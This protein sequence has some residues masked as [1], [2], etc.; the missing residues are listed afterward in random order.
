MN[1]II[2]FADMMLDGDLPNEQREH[3]EIVKTSAETLLSLIN[4]ILDFSKIEAGRIELENVPFEPERVAHEV[5]RLIGSDVAAKGVELLCDIGDRVPSEVRGDQFRF[6]QV[7]AN[8]LSNASK[9]TEAGEIELAMDV[10]RIEE[11]RIMLHVTVRDTGISI[12]AD[13]LALIFAPFRQA[14][15]STTRKHGGTGL[16]LTICKQTAELLGGDVGP[17]ARRARAAPSI[18]PHGSEN[19][20]RAPDKRRCRNFIRQERVPSSTITSGRAKSS[21]ECSLRSA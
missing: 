13:K 6:R 19:R 1:A 16:G 9:F 5:C 11:E 21:R 8:L 15:E 17:R 4:D 3:A 18:S 10:D 2:G 20:R 14:D 12:P 7:L